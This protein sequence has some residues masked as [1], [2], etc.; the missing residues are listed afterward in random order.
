MFDCHCSI[1]YLNTAGCSTVEMPVLYDTQRFI[2]LFTTAR[3]MSLYCSTRIQSTP[4]HT[5]SF[6]STSILYSHLRHGFPSGYFPSGFPTKSRHAYFFSPVSNAP[7]TPNL[8]D[9]IILT[10]I[11]GEQYI[12]R[13][14]LFAA[15]S[16][17]CHFVRL[18]SK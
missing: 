2:T 8:L 5:I 9:V 17:F 4:C 1:M 15:V 3:H 11:P 10:I 13:N 6:R 18:I 14:S 16:S 7:S 12:S